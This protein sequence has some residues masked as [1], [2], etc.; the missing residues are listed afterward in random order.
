MNSVEKSSQGKLLRAG[1]LD[2]ARTDRRCLAPILQDP[3]C[4][5]PL[6]AYCGVFTDASPPDDSVQ[7]QTEYQPTGLDDESICD[8]SV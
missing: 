5:T 2:S 7:D 8:F 1:V 4:N 3:F 6:G